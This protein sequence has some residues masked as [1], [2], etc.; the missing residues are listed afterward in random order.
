MAAILPSS[1]PGFNRADVSGT[2]KSVCG[3]LRNMH[4]NLDFDSRQNGKRMDEIERT[5]SSLDSRL[6][7][8]EAALTP[9]NNE[10]SGT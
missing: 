9:V 1:P 3:Y 4:D 5:L 7:A 2:L 8:I 10:G 6:R